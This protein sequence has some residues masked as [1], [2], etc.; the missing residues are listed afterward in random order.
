MR[1]PPILIFLAVLSASGHA[2]A[3]PLSC[4]DLAQAVQIGHCPGEEDLRFTFNGYCSD[5]ARIY[6]KGSEVCTDFQKYRDL[7]NI[8][9]WESADGLFDAYLSCDLPADAVKQARA[10]RM[11]LVKKGSIT[12]LTCHYGDRIALTHRS[13]ANCTLEGDGDCAAHPATCTARCET[14]GD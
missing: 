10:T 5:N 11:A 1:K 4:P 6:G 3:S 14:K 2:P 8:V 12:Q 9:L 13:K 7:K